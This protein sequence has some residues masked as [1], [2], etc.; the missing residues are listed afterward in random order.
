M[1]LGTDDGDPAV[2]TTTVCSRFEEI[3][4]IENGICTNGL[5]KMSRRLV[6]IPIYKAACSGLPASSN[7]LNEGALSI[8][9]RLR[10]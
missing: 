3:L 6:R 1:E 5:I 2:A 8:L 4:Q 7:C 10:F 9:L